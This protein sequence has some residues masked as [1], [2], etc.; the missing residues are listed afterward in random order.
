MKKIILI[1]FFLGA[2]ILFFHSSRS[3]ENEPQIQEIQEQEVITVTEKKTAFLHLSAEV[4][5][6]GDTLLIIAENTSPEIR[7][8][9]LLKD[10]Q[11]LE[12]S[13][14]GMY[15]GIIGIDIKQEPGTYTLQIQGVEETPVQFAVTVQK[16][17]FPTTE[18][19]VT[20]ELEDRGYTPSVIQENIVV[21]ENVLLNEVLESY[22]P[23]AYFKKSFSYPLSDISIV[24][25]YGNI[26]KSGDIELQH[27]GVDLDAHEASSVFAVNDGVVR[28]VMGLTNYGNTII[29]DHG[30]GIYSLYLHLKESIVENGQRVIRGETIALSG[31]TGYSI[32]P[33]LHFSMK[34]QGSSVDPLL[35]IGTIKK[36]MVE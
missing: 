35:F 10:I 11:F 16:R 28:F 31:N 8:T 22:A 27:K 13:E 4:L 18:L 12:T 1:L 3:F 7:A 23:E 19:V 6:Q 17:V 14:K 26:R 2:A 20:P 29:V 30:L 32:A 25:A 24:G 21:K 33:H 34:V 9:F 15:V 36:E 5:K